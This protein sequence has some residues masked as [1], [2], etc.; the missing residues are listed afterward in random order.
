MAR[1]DTATK[2]Q[3]AK[4]AQPEAPVNPFTGSNDVVAGMA[5]DMLAEIQAV[6]AFNAKYMEPERD[7]NAPTQAKM[8]TQ[9]RDETT[10]EILELVN[11][12]DAALTAVNQARETLANSM[13][14]K[15]GV[16]LAREVP[17]PEDVE[18]TQ[19][20]SQRQR[21][22]DIAKVLEKMASLTAAEGVAEFLKANPIPE[23][24]RKGSYDPTAETSGTP[25]YRVTVTA[26][27]DGQEILTRTDG[28]GF[29]KAAQYSRKFHEKDKALAAPDFRKAWEAAGNT[30][31]KTVQSPVTF[32]HDGVQYSISKR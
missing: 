15:L 24:L 11:K 25:K 12:Y 29:T 10:P 30:V 16:T 3:P 6:S 22:V 9:A 7:P 26:T 27:R 13:A 1:T 2:A 31:E 19:V 21:A 28:Q 23:V 17:K 32:E 4:K 18:L 5:N 8:V 20:K 14:R